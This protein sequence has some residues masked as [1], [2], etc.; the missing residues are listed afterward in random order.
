[1]D[2]TDRELESLLARCAL[3]DASALKV[4]YDCTA[5]YLN[6]IAMRLLRSPD[7]SN[8]VLQEA[9][10]QIWQ[11][12]GSYR[13]DLA[14]PLTW[15][16]SIVR[17]RALDR[18]AKESRHW[19][20]ELVDEESDRLNSIGGGA[21]PD[22]LLEGQKLQGML[23][24]CLEIL[25]ERNRRCVE[26]AYLEGYS[27]EELAQK[28]GTNANTIKSWLYRSAERLKQCLDAKLAFRP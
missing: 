22:Q 19:R 27:R 14:K 20:H 18:L 8:D 1:M 9:F 4:I 17:Y 10:V 7:L 5:G 12:A 3:A 21:E 13:A 15:M 6:A 25:S 24:S 2:I 11:N 28:F 16:A 23:A 26:L